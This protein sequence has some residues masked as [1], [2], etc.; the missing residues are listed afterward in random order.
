MS[1]HGRE[2]V[3]A[4]ERCRGLRTPIAW[5]PQL[6]CFRAAAKQL[7]CGHQHAVVWPD[8][9]VAARGPCGYGT[10][11]RTHSWIDDCH[12]DGPRWKGSD[13]GPQEKSATKDILRRHGVSD[14]D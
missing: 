6:D 1:G 9:R 12:V 4:M 13:R 10:A 8:E 7:E 3:A 11:F 2:D 14:I 5:L